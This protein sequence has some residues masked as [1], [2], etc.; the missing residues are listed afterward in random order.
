MNAMHEHTLRTR[1]RASKPKYDHKV[2]RP[3]GPWVPSEQ[4]DVAK[5]WA[6]VREHLQ[7]RARVIPI[8][9]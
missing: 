3:N 7:L 9:H 6:R 5:T 1:K 4:T 8:K 2:I